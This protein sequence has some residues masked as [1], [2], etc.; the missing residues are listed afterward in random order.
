MAPALAF[1]T[2]S[3]MLSMTLVLHAPFSFRT[4]SFPVVLLGFLV[5]F[6]LPH[7]DWALPWSHLCSLILKFQHFTNWSNSY[8][9]HGTSEAARFSSFSRSTSTSTPILFQGAASGLPGDHGPSKTL[10]F[11]V[12]YNLP[13]QSQTCGHKP[14]RA[15][16]N[17]LHENLRSGTFRHRRHLTYSSLLRRIALIVVNVF[18][19]RFRWMGST[20]PIPSASTCK[21][22]ISRD[23]QERHFPLLTVGPLTLHLK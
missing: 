19:P 18:S 16:R 23:S 1:A 15:S 12:H 10:F 8:W 5:Y 6:H 3:A 13:P 20:L 7:V 22:Q 17:R 14:C 2:K 11:S 4:L 9:S 21:V